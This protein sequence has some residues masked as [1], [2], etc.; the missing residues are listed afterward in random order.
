M[1][2]ELTYP[3]L[4]AKSL[5]LSYPAKKGLEY[6]LMQ[7][8]EQRRQLARRLREFKHSHDVFSE[9]DYEA[10]LEELAGVEDRICKI[11]KTL[12]LVRI[13]KRSHSDSVEL[14]SKVRLEED[15]DVVTYYLV[16]SVEADPS[17]GKISINSPLGRELVGKKRGAK[18][19][20]KAPVGVKNFKVL[21]LY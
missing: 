5:Y 20:F 4:K 12:D 8:R 13:L 9:G 11:E 10:M 14:G 3:K 17:R 2:I 21:G 7:L 16:D 18:L 19:L 15:G 1:R 6:D